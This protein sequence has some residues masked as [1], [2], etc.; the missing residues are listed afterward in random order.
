MTRQD[1]KNEKVCTLK[2]SKES[3][4]KFAEAVSRLGLKQHSWQRTQPYAWMNHD[5]VTRP[6]VFRHGL[7]VATT[8]GRALLVSIVPGRP[9]HLGHDR[10]G[11]D[12]TPRH[13]LE[14]GRVGIAGPPEQGPGYG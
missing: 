4:R 2:L 12:R 5:E 13:A 11:E 6:A 7:A 9:A 10:G 1:V 3:V 8:G 14:R